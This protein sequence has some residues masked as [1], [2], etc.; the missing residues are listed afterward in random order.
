MIT[1][2]FSHQF[3]REWIDAW[4]SHD[5]DR[6]LA[7]YADDFEMSS[8]MIVKVVGEPSGRLRGAEAVRAYWSKIL[9]MFPDLHFDLIAVLAGVDSISLQYRGAGGVLA[10]E[11]FHF[12]PHRKV[13]KA[14]A[15]YE[16]VSDE[17]WVR[18]DDAQLEDKLEL[19]ANQAKILRRRIKILGWF[20]HHLNATDPG[21]NVKSSFRFGS[22]RSKNF[23]KLD[24]II[25]DGKT[26]IVTLVDGKSLIDSSNEVFLVDIRKEILAQHEKDNE[27]DD[28][29]NLAKK[30]AGSW[31]KALDDFGGVWI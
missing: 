13:E 28:G 23:R 30:A 18:F 16:P 2:V 3:S 4:N 15:H 29:S 24:L 26:K 21:F 9:Q 27:G 1:Q 10:L 20:L 17:P 11:V 8:P 14:F 22:K 31:M 12:G 25:D 5:L 7:H 19:S 6:V